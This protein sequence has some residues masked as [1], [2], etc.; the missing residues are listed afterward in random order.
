MEALEVGIALEDRILDSMDRLLAREGYGPIRMEEVARE[1]SITRGMLYLHFQSKEDL[2]FAQTDRM[3]SRILLVEKAIAA[4]NSL[5][6][7]K[8]R[9]VLTFRVLTSFDGVQHFRDSID[10]ILRD[11]RPALID[12]RRC[13]LRREAEVISAILGQGQKRN[14]FREQER[15]S[16]AMTLLA[17]TNSLLPF[18]LGS[19]GLGTRRELE[20]K[21]AS[22]TDLL[23]NGLLRP[24]QC[25][26]RSTNARRKKN[27]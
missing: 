9:K 11:L 1:A 18:S 24:E 19:R 8:I 21:I 23:L 14:L 4:G 22:F 3:A 2:I 27:S 5:P 15:Q 6:P 7:E 16:T 12:R 20:I 13:Q 17:I 25:V 26:K 10:D